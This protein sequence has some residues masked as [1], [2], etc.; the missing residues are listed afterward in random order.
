MAKKKMDNLR[1]QRL[2]IIA[3]LIGVLIVALV[4]EVFIL[5][6]FTRKS[7]N[8][9]SLMRLNQ[10][11]SLIE[12][13]EANENSLIETLK[14]DYMIRA[15]TAAYI[16]DA[17]P[18]AETDIS[19]LNKIAG[20]LSVDEIHLF[21]AT[22]MI[23]SGT[24]PQ[25]YGYSFDSGEQMGYFKP[26]LENRDLSMC[27][28][29]TPNTAE[30]KSMMYAITWNEAGDKMIQVGIEPVRLLDELRSNEITEV[31]AN[32]PVYE[33]LEIW[34]ADAG[35]RE[36][37]ATTNHS[38]T[39]GT[40]D[41][42]GITETDFS[43]GTVVSDVIRI[44]GYHNYC[45]AKRT[46]DYIVVAACSSSVSVGNIVIAVLIEFVYLMLAGV[47]I[48]LTVTK[49]IRANHEVHEQMA[50]LKSMSDIYN[51]MLLIDLENDT[52][53][54]YNSRDE[55]RDFIKNATT[56][57]AETLKGI[58]T[59]ISEK[60]NCET[61]L[62]FTNLLTLS[63]RMQDKKFIAQELQSKEIGWYRALFITIEADDEGRPTKVIYVTQNIDQEK[64]K[65]EELIYRSNVDELTGLYNRR[66]Y[67]DDIAER[68]DAIREKNFVFV[69]LDVNGLK[70]VND[71]LGH[72][73]GDELLTG[74]AGCMKRCF[75]SYGKI[76]R[77]GGDEFA[78]IIFA[79]ETQLENIKK[80]FAQTTAGWSGKLVKSLSISTGYVARR[81]VN[82][83]S[84]HVMANL[85]DKK[86]YEAKAAFY[87]NSP[88]S[89]RI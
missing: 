89:A 85:A 73:A 63:E 20:L 17:R 28:D 78:A 38:I 48:T 88:E 11:V 65:E 56:G 22:G 52:M 36:I 49:L 87:E 59:I 6:F 64:K 81:E 1:Q 42:L 30:G 51:S 16:L 2:K 10:V 69:S 41:D 4:I 55:V 27:Q 19:E 82:T 68:G 76:Y 15:Q 24:E 18:E 34:V 8:K 5:S 74:A 37:C 44:N 46:G 53:V 62:E 40:L 70:P 84:V 23:Y 61:A 9:S 29:I 57:A 43:D 33:G 25:Y 86:M 39:S 75:G 32:M 31:V 21:D 66:A 26:M 67:E 45:K 12:E 7:A 71:T 83:D 72:A 54:E 35:T 14:E 77:T 79:S 50:I 3:Y 13:N 58:M 80:D 47:T 60:K